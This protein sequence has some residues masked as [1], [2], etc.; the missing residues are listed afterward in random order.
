MVTHGRGPLEIRDD[1]IEAL[2]D[3]YEREL[4]Q[5]GITLDFLL[6]LDPLDLWRQQERAFCQWRKNED[7]AYLARERYRQR[8][9]WEDSGG[10]YHY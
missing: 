9:A 8:L 6:D 2:F 10:M 5:L 3:S 4:E 7:A 1:A